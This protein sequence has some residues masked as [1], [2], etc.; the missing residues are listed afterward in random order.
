VLTE[1]IDNIK[2]DP[3]GLFQESTGGMMM[4]MRTAT[5]LQVISRSPEVMS[6][7]PVFAGTRVPVE[8]LIDYLA[9]GHPLEDFLDDFP[10]VSRE[11]AIGASEGDPEGSPDMKL[12]LDEI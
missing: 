8:T 1:N 9:E 3:C 12:L 6:G 2:P 11:Q 10:T 7:A 4:I 5:E